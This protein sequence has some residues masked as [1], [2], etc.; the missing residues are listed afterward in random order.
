MTEKQQFDNFLGGTQEL[1]AESPIMKLAS[2]R[3]N[4]IAAMTYSIGIK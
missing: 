3:A 2:A 1:P 4:E